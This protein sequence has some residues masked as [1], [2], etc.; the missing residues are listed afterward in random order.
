MTAGAVS[1]PGAPI[2]RNMGRP[3]LERI[4][5]AGHPAVGTSRAAYQF[6]ILSDSSALS[7]LLVVEAENEWAVASVEK[8][9]L[10][11][12]FVNPSCRV[13]VVFRDHRSAGV[14]DGLVREMSYV[15]FMLDIVDSDRL[16][17]ADALECFSRSL[18]PGEREH[19]RARIQSKGDRRTLPA[20]PPAPVAAPVP[21]P[22]HS[23]D[24]VNAFT[25]IYP[26]PFPPAPS[27]GA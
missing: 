11:D 15:D 27:R 16:I 8:L 10:R 21:N 24:G 12:G 9:L 6:A 4:L 18:S 25:E 22:F 5:Y 2:E 20:P 26:N 19:A 7:G 17:Q 13:L 23:K 14:R 1:Q 3:N